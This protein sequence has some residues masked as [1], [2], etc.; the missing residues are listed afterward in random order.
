MFAKIAVE[1]FEAG[2]FLNIFLRFWGFW[3]SFSYKN[4]SYKKKQRVVESVVCSTWF[5]IY[6]FTDKILNVFLAPFLFTG[7]HN[8]IVKMQPF[9][10]FQQIINCKFLV[11]H[12]LFSSY[13]LFFY[14]QHFFSTQPQCCLFF[15]WIELQMLIRCCLT[16]SWRRSL[17]Y[18]NQFIDLLCKSMDW[19]L[20]IG[21]RV[22]KELNI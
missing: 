11:L 18:T 17:L 8:I 2:D 7:T 1:L 21:T 6:W 12:K 9:K 3:G 4:F 15:C 20:Y 5:W 22:V 14:K 19:F 13:T 10:N 16:L